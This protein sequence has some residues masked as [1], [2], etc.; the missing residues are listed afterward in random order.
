MTNLNNVAIEDEINLDDLF[1]EIE[2]EAEAIEIKAE[3]LS[4]SPQEEALTEVDDELSGL[5]EVDDLDESLLSLDDLSL[6][7]LDSVEVEPE[8]KPKKKA[9]K[10]EV[11][12]K[13]E[14]EAEAVEAETEAVEAETEA[15]EAETEA[16]EAEAVEAKK[17]KSAKKSDSAN[18][19]RTTY[20]NSSKSKVLLNRLDGDKGEIVLEFDDVDLPPEELA[21]KQRAFLSALNNQ[22]ATTASGET[23]QKKVAEKIIILFTM[24]KQKREWN[25]VMFR[26]FKILLTDGCIQKGKDGNLMKSLLD[27]PYSLGTAKAQSGQM[28]KMLPLLKI[29]KEEANGAYEINENSTIVARLREE[30]FKDLTQQK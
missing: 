28:F 8:I 22:P 24:F 29:T 27:K 17:P 9:K 12:P 23:V 25:E 19:E 2:I 3:E 11:K 5:F 7:D 13:V 15:V 14:V 4:L 10:K 26:T 18:T 1:A 16:V 30:Y 21:E 20:F 6:D